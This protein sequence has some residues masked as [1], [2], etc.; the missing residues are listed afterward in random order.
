M[1]QEMERHVPAVD[2]TGATSSVRPAGGMWQGQMHIYQLPVLLHRLHAGRRVRDAVLGEGR[3]QDR[4]QAMAAYV[5]RFAAAAA[6]R[7]SRTS[8]APPASPAPSTTAASP[9]SSAPLGRRSRSSGRRSV[10]LRRKQ[11]GPQR[12]LEVGGC[13]LWA[14]IS[15]QA[16]QSWLSALPS[17]VLCC[18][19]WQ[20]KQPTVSR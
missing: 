17:A 3:D 11:Q 13:L 5:E 12:L 16:A 1:W 15:W 9:R 6:R 10:V 19:L 2:G 20:R 4:D 18:S 7:P 8:S 14:S